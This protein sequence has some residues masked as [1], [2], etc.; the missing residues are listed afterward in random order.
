MSASESEQELKA[1]TRRSF[2]VLGGGAVA[3]V[4]GWKWLRSRETDGGVS[5]PFRRALRWNEKVA[6]GYFDPNHRAREYP[7]SAAAAEPREN[8]DIGLGEDF[9][10]ETWNLHVTGPS[11]A[12][13]RTLTLA[14]IQ[15]LPKIEQVTA[16]NCIEGWTEVVHWGGAR[17]ADFTAKHAPEWRDAP[18]IALHTPDKEYFV[19]LDRAS[20]MHPQTLLCYEINGQRLSAAHGA[21]LR[22]VIP[23]KYGIKNI[24]RIAT[25]NY[26]ASR[27]EDYW[28]N[29]GYDWY[30]GL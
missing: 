10:I 23:V 6:R 3:G 14:D 17:F 4:A 27:P 8:G 21:P 30:A 26:S 18:Y 19:G 24:K 9:D 15:A 12:A 20:A 13:A 29:E 5:Y 2:L 22:L 28:A 7:A 11:A 1:R 16:L 25:I